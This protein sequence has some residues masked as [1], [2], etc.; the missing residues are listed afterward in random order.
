MSE[1]I[2]VKPLGP[3]IIS[4]VTSGLSRFFFNTLPLI[5][6]PLGGVTVV[7]ITAVLAGFFFHSVKRNS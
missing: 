5:F 3:S 6:S 4:A 7:A 2:F 1:L